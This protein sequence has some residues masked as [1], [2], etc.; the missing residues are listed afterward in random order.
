MN[1]TL[2][3]R[4]PAAYRGVTLWMLNDDLK[5][6][7]LAEQ[8]D[9]FRAAGWG[10]VIARTFNGLMVEYLSDEWMRLMDGIVAHCERIGLRLWL[11]AAYMPSAMPD[12]PRERQYRGMRLVRE[13]DPIPAGAEVFARDARGAYVLEFKDTI[14]NLLDRAAV[15]AYLHKAYDEIWYA[16]FARHF[17]R[18]IEAVWVDEPH[19]RP[20][21]LPWSAELP[22]RFRQ[23]WGY[24]IES[25]LPGLFVEEGDWRAVR[26]HYWRTAVSLFM[27]GYFAPVAEWCAQHGVKFAGHLMGEDTLNSQISWTGAT[28]PAYAY[29]QLP[30]IDHLTMSLRWPTGKKFILAPKQMTSVANQVGAEEALCE[31]YGVSSHRITFAERKRI[32]D[33]MAALGV[34]VRCL[35]GSFYSM[36]GRRKRIYAP[37]LADVEPWWDLNRAVSDYAARAG[38]A[39]RQGVRDA[40]VLVLHPQESVFCIYDAFAQGHEHDRSREKR[41]IA[42]WDTR[43]VTLCDALL[44]IQRDFEFGDETRL[45]ASG[46]VSRS[47]LRVGRAEYRAVVLPDLITIR[48]STLDLLLAFAAAGGPVFAAGRLP[49]AVD[50]RFGPALQA[51]DILR[52]ERLRGL[53]RPVA[54]ARAELRA[55]LDAA[56]PP[57]FRV[58][59][60]W[61]DLWA[62]FRR[63]GSRRL[64]L[65]VNTSET[66]DVRTTLRW[67]EAGR[68]ERWDL[69]QGAAEEAEQQP[70]EGGVETPIA[71]TPSATALLV[72]NT[73]SAPR[74]RRG[75]RETVVETVTLGAHPRL[76]RRAPNALTLDMAG[77]RIGAG[78]WNPPTPVIRIQQTLE[79]MRYAGAVALRF[80]F[81]VET[82]PSRIA[83]AIER[84]E[85]YV[86]EINGARVAYEGAPFF[87]DRS[88]RPVDL[89]GRVRA[90]R[91][92]LELQTDFAPV[93]KA[94][95]A[96]AS[97]YEKK[98][99]T[100]L[101]SV[102]LLG[103]FSVAADVGQGAAPDRCLRLSAPRLSR[104][105]AAVSWNLTACGYGF[106]A[107]RAVLSDR[108]LARA[109]GAGERAVL[110]LFDLHAPAATV[111][112]N[113]RKAGILKWNPLEVDITRALRDGENLVEIEFAGSLRNLLGPHHRDS[114]EPDDVWS[115][116]WN[117]NRAA[118]QFEHAEE[119]VG[120]EDAWYCIHFG[121]SRP[122][123]IEYRRRSPS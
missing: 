25:E 6:E 76:R 62:H 69:E 84:P 86:I 66:R 7:R 115:T 82:A 22:A 93:P 4:P 19:F 47:A 15:A 104:E 113:R 16:R 57:P 51:D 56:L 2:F 114:G 40:G 101:E 75:I 31:M 12:L 89:S 116:A 11:Q 59:G 32:A 45:A 24:A 41:D 90:G 44:S 37:N 43:L 39:L 107:G 34:S 109:P 87:I 33:W 97:L 64:L 99:G 8:L 102:Y 74:S 20:G 36:R 21:L 17:G 96:L 94:S 29:M 79:Q 111:R 1:K 110:R 117:D 91:N 10:A 120:W 30:G 118:T 54:P 50:G 71:L 100:E 63:A 92:T 85:D 53:V 108:V 60:D 98:T 55:A 81:E 27:E 46:R 49:E 38:Y 72:L 58:A 80:D 18:T 70:I 5:P 119:K 112:V 42:D 67:A 65:L 95:F 103:N 26:H 77:Y 61:P 13:G 78:A 122:P 48:R 3:A 52:L 83:V 28:M 123:V 9:G 23:D 14:V 35:H 106:Y 88:W 105:A 121:T 68:V 73:R